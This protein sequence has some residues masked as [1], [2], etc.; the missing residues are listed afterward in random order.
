MKKQRRL[1]YCICKARRVWAG[2]SERIKKLIWESE[3]KNKL[4]A[5]L[6]SFRI[7]KNCD[8]GLETATRGRTRTYQPANNI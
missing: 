7:V 8:Q 5:A 6:R 1:Y 2:G 4:F 3:E